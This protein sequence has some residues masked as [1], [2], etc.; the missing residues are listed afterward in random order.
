LIAQTPIWCALRQGDDPQFR[1]RHEGAGSLGEG[2]Q[3]VK[4]DL[5]TDLS[6]EQLKVAS[7]L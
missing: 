5:E 2:G 4:A 1:G 3:K 6:L 7:A